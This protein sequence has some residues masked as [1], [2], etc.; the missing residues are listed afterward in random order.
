[1]SYILIRTLAVLIA[2]YVT[3]VGVVPLA[4][5]WETGLTAVLAALTLA[6]INHTIK[7]LIDIVSIPINF[8]TLGLFSFVVNGSMVLLASHVV[9][10][11]TIPSLLM[12]IYFSVVLSVVNWV[13]HV[14]E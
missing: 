14:F 5:T 11:F 10:G 6:I 4:I 2:S 1:M 7:P 9:S 12:A 3:H 8:F 13:L